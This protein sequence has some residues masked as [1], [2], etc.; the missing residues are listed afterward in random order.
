MK[1][2]KITDNDES[3]EPLEKLAKQLSGCMKIILCLNVV[4]VKGRDRNI[5]L[6]SLAHG[7]RSETILNHF[8]GGVCSVAAA[9][10]ALHP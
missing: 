5:S 3:K 8:R 7:Q 2:S 4:Q 6:F 10:P 1:K 9:F